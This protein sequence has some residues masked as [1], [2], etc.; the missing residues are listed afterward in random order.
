[1]NPREALHD[2]AE[3][4]RDYGDPDRAIRTVGRRQVIRW[5]A[6]A[7]VLTV[8]IVGAVLMR[9]VQEKP[10][11]VVTHPMAR[12]HSLYAVCRVDCPTL[13]RLTDGR[14]I[15]IGVGTINPPGNMTISPD[16]R[17]LG[18]PEG[19][20]YV[21]RDLLG[22]TIYRV[23]AEPGGVYGPWVWSAD[24]NRIILGH[25]KDG[26]VSHYLDVDLGT[27]RITRPMVLDGN[28]IVGLTP[29]HDLILQPDQQAV[30]ELALDVA[31]RA[32]LF[33]PQSGPLTDADHGL[34][35]QSR[36]DRLYL[37]VYGESVS[38]ESFNLDGTADT[39]MRIPDGRFAVGP[40]A[41]GYVVVEPGN[42]AQRLY[43]TGEQERLLGE[44]PPRAEIVI[45]GLARH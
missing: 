21:L 26:D 15:Q 2:L 4:A 8:L 19:G 5:S 38:V 33:R 43:E 12:A 1:M 22:D 35:V 16:G 34:W 36:G 40:T 28:E 17:W 30:D 32:V 14:E 29:G 42:Q 9:P 10:V 31:G 11:T 20:G 39:L 24:S 25:H 3:D 6:A 13:L 7:T 37:L 27:G 44:Y 23:P 18:L 41:T 45:P